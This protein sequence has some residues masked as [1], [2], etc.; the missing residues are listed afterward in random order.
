MGIVKL[1]K[2]II[3]NPLYKYFIAETIEDKT[4][5]KVFSLAK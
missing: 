3:T 5:M 1:I 2:R 4:P